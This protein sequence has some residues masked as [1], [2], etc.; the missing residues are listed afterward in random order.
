ML[1]YLI[2]KQTQSTDTSGIPAHTWANL[3]MYVCD[4]TWTQCTIPQFLACALCKQ[5]GSYWWTSARQCPIAHYLLLHAH[6]LSIHTCAHEH[7][8]RKHISS[9]YL[10]G[11]LAYVLKRNIDKLGPFICHFPLF[12][13]LLCVSPSIAANLQCL[14]SC[15]TES[16]N[17]NIWKMSAVAPL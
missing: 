9:M 3:C 6:S 8:H 4:L 14:Q 12:L 11:Y 13:F 17:G 2:S 15:W 16:L 1:L 7:K 5:S 10:C